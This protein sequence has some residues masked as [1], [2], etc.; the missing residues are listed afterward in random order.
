MQ[1]KDTEYSAV[2]EQ[3][4]QKIKE[5][6]SLTQEL[7]KLKTLQQETLREENTELSGVKVNQFGCRKYLFIQH[8]AQLNLGILN[9]E[10]SIS[11]TFYFIFE[12]KVK[13]AF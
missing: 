3:M 1:A 11:L 9:A 2:E 8:L 7:N 10:L 4:K 6:T 13:F 5:I 12:M